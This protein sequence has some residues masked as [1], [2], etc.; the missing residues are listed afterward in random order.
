MSDPGNSSAPVSHS[1]RLAVLISG[2]GRTMLNLHEVIHRGEL[3]AEIA[4]VIGSRPELAGLA[5]AKAAGLRV[6]VVDRK[7][8][9]NVDAFSEHIFRIVRDAGADLVCLAGF[10]SLLNIP[11]DYEGRVI[12]IHPALLPKF[13]G[14]GMYGHHVHE[15]VLAAGER[16][17]GCTVHHCTNVYDEGGTIVQRRVPVMPGDTADTLAAR[18]FEQ[19]CIAY[20]EAIRLW[21][22]QQTRGN[23]RG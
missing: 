13:G 21:Q 5:R 7:A 6:E 16:E 8:F 23:F 11:A 15:A 14:K 10:L 3:N 22:Q 4:V 20:P 19:E 17:S 2:G 12:N 9:G 1:T 18:V